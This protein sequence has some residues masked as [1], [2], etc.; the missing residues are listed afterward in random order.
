MTFSLSF[1]DTTFN[2]ILISWKD[3]LKS[4]YENKM[5]QTGF[6]LHWPCAPQLRSSNLNWKWY[7]LVE[8]SGAYEHGRYDQI[9]LKSVRVMSNDK[10]FATDNG[11]PARRTPP[12]T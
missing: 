5:K 7:A 9:R 1:F 11:L 3:Q 2:F 8:V 6:A 4:V 12:L 10:V